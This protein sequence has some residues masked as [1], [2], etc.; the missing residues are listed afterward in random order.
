MD[1]KDLYSIFCEYSAICVDS[2]RIIPDSIFFALK[3]ENFDGNQ[4]VKQALEKGCSFAVSDDLNNA[5]IHRCTVVENVLQTL[6]SLAE[7]HRKKLNPHVLAITG[8]NGKTTTKELVGAVLSKKYKTVSTSGNFNNHIGVP[9]TLLSITEDCEIAVVEIG[10][11]HA[12]EI[13]ALCEIA[14]PNSG[15]ITNIGKAHLEGF[16][17]E[18]GVK[19]AK[20]ELYDY[21][22]K[23]G[24]VIFYNSDD[25]ILR[26]MTKKTV[27][28]KIV[29]YGK[30]SMGVET[31]QNVFL[32]FSSLQPEMRIKTSLAGQYNLNNA[33][34]AIAAGKY[35]DIPDADIVAAIS[36]CKP[37][38]N[39]SQ[40]VE[41]EKNTVIMDAYNAN[42]SSMETALINFAK[43]DRQNKML[44]LGDMLELGD[45]SR[46]EHIHIMELIENLGFDKT[47]LIG[48]NF[49]SLKNGSRAKHFFSRADAETYFADNN[50]KSNT[51]LIKG[52]RKTGLE[53]LM[54]L[55]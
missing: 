41:T 6:S 4:Y 2:R 3:G 50:P 48:E 29:G 22:N 26:E 37:E 24:G 12:G 34:A 14:C 36:D 44:I 31:E 46:K 15:I 16:G 17:S 28:A 40:L 19:K 38:N 25:K 5:G 51:I 42:P 39:R 47:V 1:T 8:T 55:L 32:A 52:S 23:T 11:N 10:A 21:L 33:L 35:F 27:N 9:L 54:Y 45:S 30:S 43:L 18:D 7:Y 53:K 49:Y 20:G 13:A